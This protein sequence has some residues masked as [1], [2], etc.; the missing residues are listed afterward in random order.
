VACNGTRANQC[1]NGVCRCG[2]LN[3]CGISRY[4][5]GVAPAGVCIFED[6]CNPI[7]P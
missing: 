5:D 3:Q 6:M 4:C 1:V 7:C 2:S